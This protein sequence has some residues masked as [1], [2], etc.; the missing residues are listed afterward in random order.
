ML[1]DKI[2]EYSSTL[3]VLYVEDHKETRD[4]MIMILEDTFGD[5]RV[6]IDGEDGLN[7]FKK[8]NFSLI[9]SDINMPKL[10]GIEMLK[11][12]RQMNPKIPIL[13][14][15]AHSDP[16]YFM[17]TIRLGIDGYL[18]K[19]LEIDQFD[20]MIDKTVNKLIL[21]TERKHYE[22][23]L[24][25]TNIE[26]E[27][28][29]K[30]KD[31]FLANMSHEIRT[32]MNAIIG[33]SHI[34]LRSDLTS[35]QS[36]YISKILT[37]GNLLLGIINDILDFS[38]IEAGK[39]DI[40]SIDF[41]LNTV[42]SNVS[43]IIATKAKEKDLELIFDIDR[44]IPLMFTG[45][46]V[47]LGQIIINL[48][49][50][51]VKFT[52]SGEV[53]LKV[54]IEEM[55]AQKEVLRFEVA[56]T[57]IGMTQEQVAKLFQSFTQADSS[58]SRQYGGTGLGLA[59]SKQLVEMM[60]GSINVESQYAIGSRFIFTIAFKPISNREKRKFR[61]PSYTMMNKKVLILNTNVRTSRVLSQMLEYF[62]YES[63]SAT[64]IES[65]HLLLSEHVFDILF[66]E[67]EIL[68]HCRPE[69]IAQHEKTK[70]VMLESGLHFDDHSHYNGIAIDALLEK[71]F[72]QEMVFNA[73]VDLYT[74]G[75]SKQENETLYDNS[76]NL[77]ILKGKTLLLAEDN[78]IN[79][80]VILG[81]LDNTGIN[82][83][84]ANN[85][86]E[87]V[88]LFQEHSQQIELILMDV[89]MPV[90]NG[91]EATAIIRK[92]LNNTTIPIVAL[93]ANAMQKDI[94]E[95]K[96]MGMD[97]HLAK[98]IDIS[99]FRS[100]LLKYL[101]SQT[102]QKVPTDSLVNVIEDEVLHVLDTDEG[103]ENLA[104]NIKLY[105]KVLNDFKV[106]FQDVNF[107]LVVANKDEDYQ[108][109]VILCHDLKGISGTIG[110][111]HLAHISKQ[112]EEGFKNKNVDRKLFSE[113][114]THYK[115]LIKEI[116]NYL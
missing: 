83:I 23:K 49:N 115:A 68:L 51:A 64:S 30:A 17:E 14:L 82:V 61:L 44:K 27:A 92:E 116:D 12:V 1:S 48:M 53:S 73:I 7:K 95:A 62:R 58:T 112:L 77:H 32:P 113:F 70:I 24:R 90:M 22:E 96:S 56:D 101:A 87:A 102:P 106:K 13:I 108:A 29:T 71:P 76:E 81:L 103:I 8:E 66:V 35:K 93:T 105:K 94:T 40:E 28:A 36:E 19:P 38:K 60:G 52:E 31:E 25:Q 104:G 74:I 11:V 37:S 15:S 98:P 100:L 72:N 9:I 33:L 16:V 89:N 4:A 42:L 85:G 18:L 75:G 111:K 110:A 57:G 6:A 79:Q 109:G 55:S 10:N 45:D 59:I 88:A 67:K 2:L 78:E 54:S 21:E 50:N 63:L 46:P 20:F 65:A 114:S 97:M 34:L 91:Y 69:V 26:L 47:R 41:N 39:L 3:K 86:Q 5:V 99:E 43:N 80:A 107:T 84:I